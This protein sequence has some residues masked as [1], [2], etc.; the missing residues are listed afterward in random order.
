MNISRKI[1]DIKKQ[2]FLLNFNNLILATGLIVFFF[3]SYDI[4]HISNFSYL[5]ILLFIILNF[6]EIE[7]SK[8]EIVIYSLLIIYI[9]FKIF[10]TTNLIN[11]IL[12][13]KFF[14]LFIIFLQIFK[15]KYIDFFISKTFFYFLVFLTLLDSFLINFIFDASIIHKDS[16]IHFHKF[17][18]F[19]QRSPSFAGSSSVTSVC[20]ISLLAILEVK[21]YKILWFDFL[22]LIFTVMILINTTGTIILCLYLFL[23]VL[24]F[25]VSIFELLFGFIFLLLIFLLFY[26]VEITIVEKYSY[27]YI[28]YII[29]FKINAFN[30]LKEELSFIELLFGS[31]EYMGFTDDFLLNSIN[32]VGIFGLLFFFMIVLNYIKFKNYYLFPLLIILFGSLHYQTIFTPPGM[33]IFCYILSRFLKSEIVT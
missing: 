10:L 4:P 31:Y 18:G 32:S 7:F 26:F 27:D 3:S 14:F 13:I 30:M 22:L 16:L 8:T 12:N 6:N 11:T 5:I 20:L 29:R 33:L 2:F 1:T 24:Y 21:K 15:L 25:K 17:F 23:R 28:T 9:I 19:Y